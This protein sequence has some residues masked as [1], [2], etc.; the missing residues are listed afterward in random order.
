M[1]QTEP[2]HPRVLQLSYACSPEHGSE[3][4]RSWCLALEMARRFE[5]WVIV[6]D[7]YYAA[8]IRRYLAAH[9]NVPRLHFVFVPD[10]PWQQALSWLPGSFYLHYKAWQW[11]AYLCARQLHQRLKFDL[12][13][14]VSFCG[15]REPGYSWKL[16]AP[17][18]WG[19]L[20]GTQ[21]YPWR[22]LT[23]AGARG[24]VAEGL[25]TVCNELQFRFS[26]RVRQAIRRTSVLMTANST[27]Q[28]DFARVHGVTPLLLLETGARA[29][30][31][32][33][34]RDPDRREVRILWSGQFEPRKC[35][36][37]LLRALAELP[38]SVDYRV[39]ILGRGAEERRWRQLARRLHV[40]ERIE[41]LGWLPLQEGFDQYQ[42][43]DLFV[44]T[45]LRD[46]AGTVAVE[47]LAAG[48]PVICLD[49]Q[50]VHDFVGEDCGA[51]IPVTTPREVV[52]RLASAIVRLGTDAPLWDQCSAAAVRRAA[53]YTYAAQGERIAALYEDL[54][55]IT[56]RPAPVEKPSDG[57]AREHHLVAPASENLGAMRNSLQPELQQPSR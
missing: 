57:T 14:Q 4:G 7:N 27:G 43:A 9:G 2:P 53:A 54:L 33:R 16:D 20:G 28:R 1:S 41:W 17:F 49:H 24:A 56:V 36:P 31:A 40:D 50:G 34:H 52:E 46:T 12:V 45:S 3:G 29:L 38:A 11:Q 22:F 55:G 23:Q 39:R 18:V 30:S 47:A 21:N 32:A 44:F 26:P 51:K 37:L 15:F 8:A 6:A 13:H 25:R 19:P 10:R 42:W 5:T 48:L 35:L